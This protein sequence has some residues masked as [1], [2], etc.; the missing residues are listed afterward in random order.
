PGDGPLGGRTGAH[1]DGRARHLAAV[2]M[3]VELTDRHLDAAVTGPAL[4]GHV[5]G[6]RRFRAVPLRDDPRRVDSLPTEEACHRPGA[7]LGFEALR[8]LVVGAL[9]GRWAAL[10]DE[11]AHAEDDARDRPHRR[12][13]PSNAA[14][15]SSSESTPSWSTSATS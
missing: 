10:Q 2:G 15:T 6:G 9:I 8:L 13:L 5:R 12:F 7:V 14:T 1:G 3:R 11:H 4:G